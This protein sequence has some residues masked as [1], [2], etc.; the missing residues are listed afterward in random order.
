MKIYITGYASGSFAFRPFVTALTSK[1]TIVNCPI[2]L[3]YY[4]CY[5]DS[6]GLTSIYRITRSELLFSLLFDDDVNNY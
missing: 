5:S 1:L 6:G 4:S 3:A 2:R